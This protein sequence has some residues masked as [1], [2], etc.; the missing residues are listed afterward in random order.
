MWLVIFKMARRQLFA[1]P[2]TVALTLAGVAVGVAVFIFT[3][4]MMDGLVAYFSQRI[5]RISP[6]LTVVP[7]SEQTLQRAV[8][9]TKSRHT[10]VVLTNPAP[11][12]Q[13]PTIR[14]GVAMIPTLEKLPGVEGVAPAVSTAAVMA[15]GT[16]SESATLLGL[17]PRRERDVT[18]LYRLVVEGSW[19]SLEGKNNAVLL[20]Y[21]LAERLGVQVGDRVLATGESGASKDLEVVGILAVGLG[22]WDEA[23]AVVPY[24]VAQGLA[25][26]NGDEVSE[27]RLRTSLQNLEALR[28]TVQSVTERKVERWEET[29]RPALQLFRTIGLTTYLLTAFVLVVAGL[30]ISNKLAT[31]ILNKERDIAILRAY[32]FSRGAVRALFLIQGW[33][34]GVFGAL[35]GC[36]LAFLVITYFR[37]HPIRFAP[38]ERA[39]LAYTELY[40]A[41][42]P[43]YYVFVAVVAMAIAVVAS[44]LAVRRAA[45][46]LPVEVLRGEA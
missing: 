23:T 4:A 17:D 26:W 7:A 15:F 9:P 27:L 21:K 8:R 19:Q 12:D 31:V 25:G 2:T 42:E 16:I 14:G 29:N 30:G 18:D 40:L 36:F 3:V 33:L 28:Q 32:G 20:G 5:L 43:S 46:V 39:V 22:S 37:A 1:S 44:L 45:R 35:L 41:N 24:A 6:T 13:R 10:V 38:R 34:L 11:P